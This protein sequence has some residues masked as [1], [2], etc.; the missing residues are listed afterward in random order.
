MQQNRL[1]GRAPQ[2]PAG[3][4]H[5]TPSDPLT[6]FRGLLRGGNGG[7]GKV[8]KERKDGKKREGGNGR[9]RGEGRE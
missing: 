2:G 6:C 8:G 3:E 5:S 9:E 4:T 1:L 7:E